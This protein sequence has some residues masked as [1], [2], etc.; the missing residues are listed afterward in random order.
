MAEGKHGRVLTIYI[1]MASMLLGVI[2]PQTLVQMPPRFRQ[3]ALK[4]RRR[5]EGEMAFHQEVGVL[6]G[7]GEL[8]ELLGDLTSSV[9]FGT[10]MIK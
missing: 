9:V 2:P 4:E 10:D 8:Q 7:F 5:T 6:G 1:G 3:V